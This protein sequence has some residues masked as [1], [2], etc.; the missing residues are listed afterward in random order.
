MM[1]PKFYR[2]EVSCRNRLTAL[3]SIVSGLEV[4]GPLIRGLQGNSISTLLNI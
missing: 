3:M 1:R 2:L 4:R